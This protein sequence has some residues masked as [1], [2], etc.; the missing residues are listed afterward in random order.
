[1]KY[2]AHRKLLCEFSKSSKFNAFNL[3]GYQTNTDARI[4]VYN[5]RPKRTGFNMYAKYTRLQLT[6]LAL[7]PC[8]GLYKLTQNCRGINKLT[9]DYRRLHTLTQDYRELHTLTQD[10][11][12][13]RLHKLT[14]DYRELQTHKLAHTFFKS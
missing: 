13:R 5:V 6:F 10:Y 11:S 8:R 1:M 7:V 4:L 3:L 12:H 2:S 14:N 9:Q